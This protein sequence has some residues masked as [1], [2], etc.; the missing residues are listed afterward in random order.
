MD[1]A[2]KNMILLFRSRRVWVE[3]I[4]HSTEYYIYN[5]TFLSGVDINKFRYILIIKYIISCVPAFI[6]SQNKM[7][8]M[9]N[10]SAVSM[11]FYLQI[12]LVAF[13]L[14]WLADSVVETLG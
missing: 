14:N 12:Y 7:D 9:I 6:D 10:T 5:K 1:G 13:F 4:I 2:P 3:F 8:S 11:L